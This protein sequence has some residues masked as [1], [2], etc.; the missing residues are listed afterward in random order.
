[1]FHVEMW[2]SAK[3]IRELKD[4][5]WCHKFEGQL[6]NEMGQHWKSDPC[7]T[8]TEFKMNYW[9]SLWYVKVSSKELNF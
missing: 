5:V 2:G 1:M 4:K 6:R 9:Q 3:R 8:D 7:H